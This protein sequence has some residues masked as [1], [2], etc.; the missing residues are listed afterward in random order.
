MSAW[1]AWRAKQAAKALAHFAELT[2]DAGANSP[3]ETVTD[4][5][6]NIGHYCDREGIDWDVV[7]A[8]AY[9]ALEYERKHGDEEYGDTKPPEDE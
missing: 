7:I 1:N 2:G 5:L 3:E 6:C 8:K 4:L 9:G